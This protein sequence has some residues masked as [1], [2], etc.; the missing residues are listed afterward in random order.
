MENREKKRHIEAETFEQMTCQELK[1]YEDQ[2]RC[3]RE[4]K[5]E[6]LKKYFEEYE[7]E[8]KTIERTHNRNLNYDK[9]LEMLHKYPEFIN[10]VTIIN[11]WSALSLACRD[12]NIN[13][14][15]ELIKL[16]A[17][18]NLPD[19]DKDGWTPFLMAI[20]TGN[21]EVVQELINHGA[22][23]NLV[24]GEGIEIVSP[25][26][27]T[28]YKNFQPKSLKSL[29]L[30]IR[31]NANLNVR[32]YFG[33]TPLM[34]AAINNN[35]SAIKL[36]LEAGANKDEIK[37][38]NNIKSTAY[39]LCK[40]QE[41]RHQFEI[42]E[43]RP[44][45]PKD[46]RTLVSDFNTLDCS[47]DLNID[48]FAKD[49]LQIDLTP[50]WDS[51]SLKKKCWLASNMISL[52][53]ITNPSVRLSVALNNYEAAIAQGLIQD[54]PPRFS[55]IQKKYQSEIEEKRRTTNDS[56]RYKGGGNLFY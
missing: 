47:S 36:L 14:V 29:P 35:I 1:N 8:L 20:T 21:L 12:G 45:L 42:H 2:I 39:D 6:E 34:I 53:Q 44:I 27:A 32:N 43:L 9:V 41:C 55:D 18:I 13:V 48:Q 23:V 15:R 52:R 5:E 19:T 10:K 28:V 50:E 7:N 4:R 51:Y 30:L 24:T 26:L 11:K 46:I 49:I 37:M 56:Y 38:H 17:D 16:G 33:D 31:A 3:I 40:T 54:L 25:V 22:N